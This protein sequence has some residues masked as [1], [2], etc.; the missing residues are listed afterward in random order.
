MPIDLASKLID[1]NCCA[2]PSFRCGHRT[3]PPAHAHPR[4]TAPPRPPQTGPRSVRPRALRMPLPAVRSRGPMHARAEQNRAAVLTASRA[5]SRP[6]LS[7]AVW[8]GEATTRAPPDRSAPATRRHAAPTGLGPRLA[9]HEPGASC[10]AAAGPRHR[11]QE[12]NRAFGISLF[13]QSHAGFELWGVWGAAGWRASCGGYA[14]CAE[15]RGLACELW[16][17]WGLACELW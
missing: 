16:A 11:Y 15:C 12:A 17:V 4:G 10:L 13:T 1:G 3:G 7:A 8:G 2:V 9:G 14:S 6:G 5:S